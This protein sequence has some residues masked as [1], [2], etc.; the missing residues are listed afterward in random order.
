MDCHARAG[1]EQFC[2]AFNGEQAQSPTL[3]IGDATSKAPT[4]VDE[5]LRMTADMIDFLESVV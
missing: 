5:K 1:R 4:R 2:S 3:A